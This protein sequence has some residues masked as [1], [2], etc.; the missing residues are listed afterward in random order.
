MIGTGDWAVDFADAYPMCDV[1]GTGL[2]LIQPQYVRPNCRFVHPPTPPGE[3]NDH[4]F[5]GAIRFE[6]DD[7]EDEWDFRRGFDLI[8]T[9]ASVLCWRNYEAFVN[10]AYQALEPGGWL[11]MQEF[12]H[13][14][15]FYGSTSDTSVKRYYD[16]VVQG[17]GRRG[18]HVANF[19]CIK[20]LMVGRGFV[21]I[22]EK[23]FTWPFGRWA[24]GSHDGKLRN[25]VRRN[26]QLVVEAL[27]LRPLSHVGYS[28]DQIQVFLAEVRQELRDDSVDGHADMYDAQHRP[29]PL[30]RV[31]YLT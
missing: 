24:Q 28:L 4:T 18:I 7:A 16:I 3:K 30:V 5:Y 19:M 2:S 15:V 8:H 26:F 29:L 14:P 20:N 23:R 11:E 17:T 25:L 13:Q 27:A 1:L 22:E 10:Q 31:F 9:R 6:L 12:N 21:N